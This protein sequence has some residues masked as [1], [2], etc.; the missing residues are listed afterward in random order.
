MKNMPIGTRSTTDSFPSSAA[1][2]GR[3]SY[4]RKRYVSVERCI[5]IFFASRC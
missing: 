4:D 5:P 3:G 1:V 2:H